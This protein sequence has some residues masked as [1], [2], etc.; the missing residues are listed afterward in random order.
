MKTIVSLPVLVLIA[1][2]AAPLRADTIIVDAAGGGDYAD[3]GAAVAAALDGD[4]ILVAPGTYPTS[5]TITKSLTIEG[6]G[7]A[8]QVIL[9]GGGQ[10]IMLLAGEHEV[11]LRRLCLQHG[12]ADAGGGIFSW[13][14]MDLLAEDCIFRDNDA[15]EGGGAIEARSITGRLTLRRCAFTDN[16]AGSHAGGVAVMFGIACEIDACVFTHNI[17]QIMAGAFTANQAGPVDIRHTVFDHNIGANHGAVYLVYCGSN[18]ITNCTF[19]RTLAGDHAAVLVHDA[20]LLM[21]GNIIAGTMGGAGVE[22]YNSGNILSE[23]NIFWDNDGGDWMN[24]AIGPLDQHVD[25]QFCNPSAGD[26]A[27]CDESPAVV[28]TDYGLIGALEPGCPCGVIRTE[29][30]TWTAVKGI[31]R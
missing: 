19:Y 25:P 6:Q 1:V 11:V 26:L 12:H 3:L 8:E 18:S 15:D 4:T 22:I 30:T 23:Y 13:L 9:D 27:P 16:V 14:G 20:T 28:G 24:G 7:D 5:V 29:A 2:A 10:R 17:A 21:R 31:F